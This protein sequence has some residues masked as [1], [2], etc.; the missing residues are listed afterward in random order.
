MYHEVTSECD[1]LL[2]VSN[3]NIS[4]QKK[5]ELFLKNLN[6]IFHQTLKKSRIGGNTAHETVGLMKAKSILKV[7]L[8]NVQNEGMKLF[9]S[10][11]IDS[12]ENLISSDCAEENVKKFN[13]YIQSVETESGGFSLHGMWKLKSKLCPRPKD[14]PTAKLDRNGRLVTNPNF[15]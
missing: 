13:E 10:K 2:A 12:I 3:M 15:F 7:H 14:P 6:N 8:R 1:D 4:V 9:L 5:S 11:K